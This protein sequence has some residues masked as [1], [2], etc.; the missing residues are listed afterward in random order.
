MSVNEKMTAIADAIREKTGKSELITL[1]AMPG[2]I[3]GIETGGGGADLPEEAFN[4]TGNCQYRFKNGGWDWFIRDY[5]SRV[6][7]SNI[8]AL[9]Y[10]FENSKVENIPFDLNIKKSQPIDFIS[11]FN[12]C[13]NLKSIPKIGNIPTI[14]EA[15]NMFA[16]CYKLR[17]L[18][19][20]IADWF[21]WSYMDAQTSSYSCNRSHMFTSCYSLRSI[22]MNFL[23]HATP[24]AAGNYTYFYSGF[25]Q[26]YVLDE[27]VGLPI[28]YTATYTSNLFNSTFDYNYRL[29]NMTFALQ[30]NGLPI[31]VNWKSQ[32]INLVSAGQFEIGTGKPMSQWNPEYLESEKQRFN[33]IIGYN[34]GITLDKAIYNDE[35]YALLKDDPDSFCIANTYNIGGKDYRCYDYSRYN[36]DSA[37]ATINSLPDTSAYLATAGGTNNIK[38]KGAAGAKTDGGAINTLT[39]EEIAVATAKGW[40]VSL[41]T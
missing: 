9:G 38:F 2:E 13:S 6:N 11:L 26:C 39:Q 32:T 19:E 16:F 35:T 4:I 28:P 41:T 3:R 15:K 14:K 10:M 30:E 23:S 40:T 17:Y 1:D 8:E 34:S 31:E 27:L 24:K 36:H 21:D 12:N 7:T 25:Q 18:P 29:K 22:P 37:V 33:N 20:D 5:G